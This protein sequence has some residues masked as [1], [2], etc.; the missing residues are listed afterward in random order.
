MCKTGVLVKASIA[1]GLCIASWACQRATG[2]GLDDLRTEPINGIAEMIVD[3]PYV[4]LN[5]TLFGTGFSDAVPVSRGAFRTTQAQE[6]HIDSLLRV[7]TLEEKAG[8]MNQYTSFYDVTGPAP[9]EG[10]AAERLEEV[11][12]GRVGSMLNV[13][14]AAQTRK[15]QEMAL[16]SRLGIPLIFGYDVIHGYKTQFPVPL[17]E[18]ATWDDA[19]VERAAKRAAEE[20][21]A[22]GLHWT[23]APMVDISPD[24]RWGR[25]VEGAGED[26]FLGVR[27]ARARVRGFQGNDLSDPQTIAACAKHFAGYGYSLGGRDY[28]TVE[29][30][31]YTLHNDVLPPF[32]AAIE[33]GV[34][35]FMNGFTTLAGKPVTGD[36]YLQRVWLKQQHDWPGLI[37]SDWNSIGELVPHGVAADLSEAAEQAVRAG[38]DMDMETRAY[39]QHLPALVREGKLSE[40]YLDDAV[41]RILRVKMA[42]GLFEDPFRYC[43]PAREAAVGNDPQVK[44]DAIETAARS[45]VLLKN[46]GNALPLK[47][48]ERIAVIGA[49]AKD[50]DSPL[51]TWLAA[52]ERGGATSLEEALQSE[53]SGKNGFSYVA[54]PALLKPG[55]QGNF[56]FELDIN[57]SDRSGWD[58]AIAAAAKAER[59]LMV[60]G[61]PGFMTGEARSRTDL[62]LPGLQMELLRAVHAVNPRIVV[63]LYA[64]RPLALPEVDSLAEAI[65][66]AWQPG[67]YGNL[68]IAE[69]LLGERDP[70]GKLPVS[71]PYTVGQEPLTYREYATGRPGSPKRPKAGELVFFSHYM[72][73]PRTALY[74]FGHGLSY[75]SFALSDLS[76]MPM[77]G[78]GPKPAQSGGQRFK[79]SATLRNTGAREADETIQLYIRDPVATRVRPVRELKGY[80]RSVLKPGESKTLSFELSESDLSFWTPEKGWHIEPGKI[81]VW[82]GT[83]SDPA[84]QIGPVEIELLPATPKRMD[85]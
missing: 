70:S 8:Q 1:F 15:I 76:A 65:L 58:E 52:A 35:T 62:G 69:V 55:T 38:S 23:F 56:A 17:A 12:S 21:S 84:D 45:A 22:F 83:S 20:A 78:S 2:S 67:T 47:A 51:G 5:G 75:S 49:L 64:G 24:A 61:E 42:L 36:T 71:F 40:R 68:G 14:G 79:V 82:V 11:R 37:V 6:N 31:D 19:I 9:T 18:V 81:Q 41:R 4:D 48:S 33:E 25:I 74:P 57:T 46:E 13:A 44:A 3:S 59:V 85:P 80:E 66:L 43:D 7:M 50:K 16:Q 32:K 53:T 29:L 77:G 26:P 10:T 28:N 34:A 30:S 39:V 63:V 60:L 54:G 72:D 27:M 73:A